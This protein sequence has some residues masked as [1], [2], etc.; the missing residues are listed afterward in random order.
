MPMAT[1]K[2]GLL[3]LQPQSIKIK[4]VEVVGSLAGAGMAGCC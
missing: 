1:K 2:K 4:I 3:V